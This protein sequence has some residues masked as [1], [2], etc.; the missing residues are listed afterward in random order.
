MDTITAADG[1]E[2]KAACRKCGATTPKDRLWSIDAQGR[3]N[4][5]PVMHD[6][7]ICADCFDAGMPNPD[8]LDRLLADME[9]CTCSTNQHQCPLHGE[10]AQHGQ[11]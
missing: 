2:P 11:A 9:R 4:G 1:P 8:G 10:L 7:W 6:H 3:T 5:N